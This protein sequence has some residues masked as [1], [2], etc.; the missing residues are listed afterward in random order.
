MRDLSA[1]SQQE[2]RKKGPQ[3]ETNPH[4]KVYSSA[5]FCPYC[6]HELILKRDKLGYTWQECHYCNK[7]MHLELGRQFVFPLELPIY[8]ME[9]EET[10]SNYT[11]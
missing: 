10:D 3:P 5:H 4:G 11:E 7:E 6:A 9:K 8:E 1:G 2:G